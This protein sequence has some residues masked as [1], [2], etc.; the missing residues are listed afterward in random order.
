[1]EI[2]TRIAIE[3]KIVRRIVK[4]A[5]QA[6]YTVSVY[7]GETWALKHSDNCKIIN[8]ALFSTDFDTL[9]LRDKAGN[10][11]GS[12]YCIYGNDGYDVISDYSI[13]LENFMK[14]IEAYA[15][16]FEN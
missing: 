11:Q 13:A 5:L 16:S 3:Q 1:M 8:A 7:D 15:E 10:N 14:P 9:L 6:G 2:S 12:I 4:E